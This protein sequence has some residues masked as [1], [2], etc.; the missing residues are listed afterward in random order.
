MID[1]IDAVGAHRGIVC[2]IGA[3]GKKSVLY[4][5]LREHPGRVA[6]TTS[7]YTTVFPEDLTAA[8]IVDV[9]AK[10]PGRVAGAG[11][12][13]SIAYACPSDKPG[14]FAGASVDTI[15]SIHAACG[16]EATFVKA[17]G[18]R[19]R[20]IKA[21]EADEPVLVPDADL[22]IPVVSARVI[23]EPLTERV[24]H[25]LE[26]VESVTGI[27]RGTPVTPEAVGRLLASE[28]GALKG[29]AGARVAPVIN[30]VDNDRQ[31]E[32]ARAAA[33]AAIEMTSRF[34]RVVLCCL[35]RTS[36]PVV[37]VVER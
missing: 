14:R 9:E 3:G 28:E 16:F 7:A 27:A 18:A 33:T 34:D 10:L 6:L 5:L 21:P 20:W 12:S 23:G 31:E 11:G 1:L 2:A 8:Q 19:M 32:M 15:R 25:R 26:R 13:R 30:M 37:A 4:Q 29:V 24:A 22:V 35:R 36:S 17:D